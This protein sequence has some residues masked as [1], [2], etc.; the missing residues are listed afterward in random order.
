LDK[1]GGWQQEDDEHQQGHQDRCQHISV[2]HPPFYRR[3]EG[4]HRDGNDGTPDHGLEEGKNDPDAPDDEQKKDNN[5][6]DDI[7]Q[8]KF[9]GLVHTFTP[10]SA[11]VSLALLVAS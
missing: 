1:Q 4:V 6:D 5:P 10:I 3:K 9:S 11:V 2:P 7:E 8:W